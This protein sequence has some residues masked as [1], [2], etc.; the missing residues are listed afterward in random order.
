MPRA[1]RHAV[2]SRETRW[3]G[4]AGRLECC[5]H[6]TDAAGLS[7]EWSV[8]EILGRC[9][10]GARFRAG[11]REMGIVGLQACA[12][13]FSPCTPMLLHPAPRTLQPCDRV[14]VQATGC[15]SEGL[16]SCFHERGHPWVR[17][18]L[19]ACICEVLVLESTRGVECSSRSWWA[20]RSSINQRRYGRS[21]SVSRETRA[22]VGRLRK[23]CD[24]GTRRSPNTRASAQ[25]FSE[26]SVLQ[27][28]D[29]ATPGVRYV[30]NL[31]SPSGGRRSAGSHERSR[32]GFT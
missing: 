7:R 17:T 1:A 21:A 16:G 29:I 5:L 3:H 24:A 10:T 26:G 8:T 15:A 18:S 22:S 28:R 9:S 2:V 6:E 25:I 30:R 32:C 11:A 13:H 27:L 23:R 12:P 19:N 31:T 20:R 14:G 4:T